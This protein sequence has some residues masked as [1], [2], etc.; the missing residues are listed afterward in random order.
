[1][2]KLFFIP[3]LMLGF[4]SNAQ[5]LSLAL[6]KSPAFDT[7]FQKAQWSSMKTNVQVSFANSNTRYAQ[8]VFPELNQQNNASLVA[9]KGEKV[10]AQMLVL[11]KTNLASVRVLKNDL[12]SANGRIIPKSSISTGFVGYVITD[13]F[14]DGCGYRK[15]QDFDS[16]L[17]AD[18][19]NE[20]ALSAVQKKNT[21][22]P[23]WVSINVPS[24][25]PAGNYTGT[26]AV[27]ADKYYRLQL[28]IQVLDKTLPPPAQWK[29][30]LDFWQHPA[31]IARVHNVKLWSDAHFAAMKKYYTMLANAGQKNIT[32]SIVNEPWGHQTYD[33][34]PG[35]VKWIKMKDGNWMYDYSLFD[36]YISFVMS[37]GINQRINC[38]SM[39]PW[40]I[41]F[42]YYDEQI[43]KDTAFTG[44]I[45]S[46]E[47]NV[48][49]SSMLK[50]F[51][52]HLKQKG[53]FSITAIAMDERPMEAMQAV[54][55]LLKEI[56]NG[57]KIALAGDY[58]ADIEKDVFDY[59]IASRLDFPNDVLQQRSKQ[60]KLSTW[61]TCCTEKYPNG[62]TFSP[63]AEHVWI[64]WY[65]AAKNM[66][67]Y[68]RWAYN[69]WTKNPLQ[70]S[71]FTAWP[72]GDT[73]QVYPGPITSI[74]FE[75]LIE[76]IQD[77]E[78]INVLKEQ[79]KKAGQQN[80]LSELEA[81][82]AKFD[83]EKLSTQ[84]AEEMVMDAKNVLNK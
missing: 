55:K 64:G 57:W 51:T 67:G 5:D 3:A 35:L 72:A 39:V 74:R 15:P 31:A 9:W 18:P 48:F 6:Q 49:W 58:H 84:S 83:I 13:E 70:D 16:S 78:K 33:D 2:K 22:Q 46:D 52:K 77:F 38:Y 59:C 81:V 56:D 43:G 8:D 63:P 27:K 12:K 47:Y 73:Y 24:N 42:Q 11:S 71:R 10:H 50:D 17:V 80:K 45:G 54:I 4:F 20:M 44:K 41:A 40:K 79:Y 32:A 66:N 61:Y 23:L 53:W 82:L 76:G 30:N 68:L 34:Y 25:I 28:T 7:A 29:F 19:I 65:T 21:V 37:C 75:K 26:I 14:K 1:M 69:S 36:K 62:F 60:G